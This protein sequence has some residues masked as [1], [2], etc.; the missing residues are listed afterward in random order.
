MLNPSDIVGKLPGGPPTNVFGFQKRKTRSFD[1]FNLNLQVL[2]YST[3]LNEQLK[4]RFLEK[5][6]F[7]NTHKLY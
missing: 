1:L 3:N 6:P 7:L 4:P 2:Q 5:C